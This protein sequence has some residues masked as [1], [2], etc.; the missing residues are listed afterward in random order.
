MMPRR[1]LSISAMRKNASE[2]T[3]GRTQRN[4]D[5]RVAFLASKPTIA[6]AQIAM[7]AIKH[8]AAAGIRFHHAAC[9]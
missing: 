9:V 2:T 3:R 4:P 8:H 5:F 7:V 6:L 1:G